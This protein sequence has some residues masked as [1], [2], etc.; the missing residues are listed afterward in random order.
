MLPLLKYYGSQFLV[1]SCLPQYLELTSPVERRE[2][3]LKIHS[4]M[5]SKN[6]GL[7]NI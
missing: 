5:V 7:Y 3:V 1:E 6:V 4:T 2:I